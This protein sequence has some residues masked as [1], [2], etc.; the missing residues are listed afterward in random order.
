[1]SACEA[2]GLTAPI[3]LMKPRLWRGLGIR[4]NLQSTDKAQYSERERQYDFDLTFMRRSLSLSP[5]SSCFA[6]AACWLPMR[7]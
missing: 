7:V 3:D 2:R 6:R 1:M 4:L 5:V